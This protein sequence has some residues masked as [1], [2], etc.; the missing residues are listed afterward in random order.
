VSQLVSCMRTRPAT[1]LLSAAGADT[2]SLASPRR[3]IEH[4]GDC[5]WQIEVHTPSNYKDGEDG[6]PNVYVI[7]KAVHAGGRAVR[8]ATRE[9]REPYT[10]KQ[11][12][13]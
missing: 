9:Q 10:I 11:M 1:D 5:Q 4:G 8:N 12:T 3:Q 6:A 13:Y 2:R 7:K